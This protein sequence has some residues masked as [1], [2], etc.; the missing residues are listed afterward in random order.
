MAV[1]FVYT[2]TALRDLKTWKK[3]HN[4][5]AIETIVEVIQCKGHY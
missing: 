1:L 5:S 2:P 3:Q 4:S